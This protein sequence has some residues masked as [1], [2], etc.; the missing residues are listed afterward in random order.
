MNEYNYIHSRKMGGVGYADLAEATSIAQLKKSYAS[1]NS[2]GHSSSR[3]TQE[4]SCSA[5]QI[6]C[7]RIPLAKLRPYPAAV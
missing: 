6:S 3:L 5:A 7:G 1:C 4:I 2:R